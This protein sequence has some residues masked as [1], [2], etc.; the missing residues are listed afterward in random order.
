MSMFALTMPEEFHRVL[1]KDGLFFQVLAAQDH[2]LGL[3]GVIY[4]EI[5]LK[6][7]DSVPE[8][9][10]FSL[11]ESRALRFPI[12]A[13]GEQIMNL[14][15]MTPHFWRISAEGAAR[16]AGTEILHDTASVVINVYRPL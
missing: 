13:E 16:L 15:S 2:L 4:P 6:E 12:C 8:I 7:K 14:L 10:G 3:K 1:A 5:L 11:A 9:P